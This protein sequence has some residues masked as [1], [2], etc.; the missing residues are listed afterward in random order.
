MTIAHRNSQTRL[1]DF[2]DQQ[3]VSGDGLMAEAGA[4]ME[5]PGFMP[6]LESCKDMQR[7]SIWKKCSDEP[8]L[9]EIANPACLGRQ[10]LPVCGRCEDFRMNPAPA[11]IYLGRPNA[12]H[13]SSGSV[14]CCG[15]ST[16]RSSRQ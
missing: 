6:Q 11:V 15:M 9:M 14:T 16:S 2:V 10:W 1:H 3:L 4:F 13:V 8:A 7:G 5:D 12:E